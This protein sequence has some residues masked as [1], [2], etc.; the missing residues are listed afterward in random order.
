MFWVTSPDAVKTSLGN[1][2]QRG[3]GTRKTCFLLLLNETVRSEEKTHSFY[4]FKTEYPTNLQT[5]RQRHE[6][7][8][9]KEL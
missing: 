9:G 3:P 1:G 6:T 4:L 2:G 5:V 7:A 8:Q